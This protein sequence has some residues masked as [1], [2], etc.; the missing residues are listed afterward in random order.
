VLLR[1]DRYGQEKGEERKIE[2]TDIAGHGIR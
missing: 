2:P 1:K